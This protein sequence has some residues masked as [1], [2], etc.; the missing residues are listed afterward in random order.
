MAIT[1]VFQYRNRSLK[2]AFFS[3]SYTNMNVIGCRLWNS[4]VLMISLLL[5]CVYFEA[6][7]IVTFLT[8][9]MIRQYG[10]INFS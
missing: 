1:L 5:I 6:I 7:E 3:S 8:L 10:F 9:P 4:L 2:V